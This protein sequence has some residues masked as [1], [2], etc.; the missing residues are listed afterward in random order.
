MA[1]LRAPPFRTR[2]YLAAVAVGLAVFG[3]GRVTSYLAWGKALREAGF[4]GE[5]APPAGGERLL[6][7]APHPDDEALGCGGLIQEALRAGAEVHVVLMTNGDAS[8]LALIFGERELPSGPGSFIDLGRKRQQESL[9]A[10][11]GL[12]LN[13]SHVHFLGFPNNGLLALWRPEHW[14]YSQ[15]YRSPYTG[16]VY[17]PYDHIVTPEAPY[18]GQ[19]VLADLMAVLQQ[20]RPTSIFVTA[21]QDV[22]PD[23]WATCCFV[24]YALATVAVRGAEW[25]RATKVYGY[26]VHWPRFPA[27]ARASVKLALLP[28]T[29]LVG[30]AGHWQRLSLSP[31]IAR[32]KLRAIR[33]YRSQEPGLDRLLLRFA[34]ANEVYDALDAVDMELGAP[35][36]WTFADARRRGLGGARVSELRLDV[37]REPALTAEL[38]T[39]PQPLNNHAYVGLD[40]RSWDEGAAPALTTIYVTDGDAARVVRLSVGGLSELTLAVEKAA[41]GRLRIANVPLPENILARGEFFVTCWGSI[42]DRVTA[43]A[44]VSQVRLRSAPRE[45]APDRGL[46]HSEPGH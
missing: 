28:P 31:D 18:C 44:L 1:A 41:P 26:L 6:I 43:P 9:R 20:V 34:R 19:Q 42:G 3:Y 11:A 2:A 35:R 15:P 16:A 38:A 27:P 13:A 23:H 29:S 21:P 37:T 32:A 4:I 14:R 12:G 22:H 17:S 8:E 45:P 46:A 24:R 33:A 39:A 25:A 7:V 36:V 5:M 40:V 30:F 10:L